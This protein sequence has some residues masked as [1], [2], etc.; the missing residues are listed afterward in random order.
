MASQTLD[1]RIFG[2]SG[3]DARAALMLLAPDH[4]AD[5]AGVLDRIARSRGMPGEDAVDHELRR[6]YRDPDG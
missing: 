4:P 5:V 3:Q 6:E 1:E 2:L